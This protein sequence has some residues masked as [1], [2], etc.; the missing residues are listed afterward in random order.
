MDPAD[1]NKAIEWLKSDHPPP[2][3]GLFNEPDL[4][5]GGSTPVTLPEAAAKNLTTLINAKPPS[6]TLLS[7]VPAFPYS[8]WLDQFDGNC[9]GCMDKIDIISAHVY[10][11]KPEDSI[12]QI[13]A[14]HNRWQ[15][16]IWVTEISPTTQV[17]NCQF[18]ADEMSK[19]MTTVVN[20]IKKLGYVEKIFWNTGAYGIL[21]LGYENVCNPSL[22]KEDGSPTAVLDTYKGLCSS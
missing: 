16:P 10:H 4:S 14:I 22:T 11:V 8:D 6:T 1:T 19:Y 9:T 2:Y 5:Y 21:G 17:G 3:L 7:P 12:A 20:G 13:E 15:K 18:S